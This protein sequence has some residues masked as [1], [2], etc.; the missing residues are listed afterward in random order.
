MS[1]TL[2]I[3]HKNYSSWSLRPWIFLKHLGL[4]FREAMLP[5]Y[6]DAFASEIA[7]YSPTGKVPALADGD[8]HVWDSLAI[9]E[10]L[11]EK[12]GRGWPRD[13]SARALA[14]SVSAEM[15]SGFPHLRAQCAMNIRG[16]RRVPPTPELKRDIERI[17]AIW[18]DCRTRFG[19]GGA[20]LFG[21]YSAA[22]AMYLPV[23]TRFNTYGIELS[24][25]SREYLKAALADPF[26]QEWYRAAEA[27]TFRS[28][29]IDSLGVPAQ[30]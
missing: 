30:A 8:V 10:Y 27:E 5:L 2:A 20:W 28:Q 16:R 23:A 7:K 9:I 6:T 4:E 15:H 18:R 1:L 14:R 26:F 12:A 29:A 17:D 24:P 13:V 11:A 22:D 19:R 21:E 3:G 25:E